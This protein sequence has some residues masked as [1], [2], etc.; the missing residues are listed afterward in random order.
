[1]RVKQ[2]IKNI[3]IFIPL[4]SAHQFSNLNHIALATWGF[5]AFSLCASGVY[6]LNDLFDLDADRRHPKKKLRPFASGELSIPYGL[7]LIPGLFIGSLAVAGLTLPITFLTLLFTYAVTT[8]SYSIFFKQIAIV[9]VLLLAG[10]YTARVL[11][12]GLAINVPISAWLLAFSMF[13]FLSLA[14]IK[15]HLELLFR[16]VSSNQGLER[17][18][19]IGLDKEALGTMGTVSGY[20]SVLVLALYI[21]SEEVLI[22]YQRPEMLWLAC[23]IL[24][25]WLSRNWLLAYRGVLEDDPI[26]AALKDPQSYVLA[27][28]IGAVLFLAI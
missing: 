3:L 10:L 9:D 12:G 18:A 5:I 27:A 23:P 13:F 22:R 1:M 16:K 19:Y 6:V 14:F 15:R 25:Y 2:W 20:L 26:V 28:S 8:T 17:R 4:F 21:N 7:L 24:L 11:A